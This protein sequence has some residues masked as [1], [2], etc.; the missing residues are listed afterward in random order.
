MHLSCNFTLQMHAMNHKESFNSAIY[1]RR[2]QQG[3]SSC[4]TKLNFL[5]L[6]I[7]FPPLHRLCVVLGGGRS[8]RNP[9]I[10]DS[11][12]FYADIQ[13]DRAHFAH[14]IH[15]AGGCGDT[16]RHRCCHLVDHLNRTAARS[17][18]SQTNTHFNASITLMHQILP[19][20]S[21]IVTVFKL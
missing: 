6:L 9:C 13:S 11:V 15:S 17:P 19:W 14:H 5:F 16:G 8:E 4:G 1:K 18:H 21:V 12:Q 10:S 3:G 7:S 20:E 2:K